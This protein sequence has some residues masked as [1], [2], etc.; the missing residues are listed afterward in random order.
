[1]EDFV[2]SKVVGEQWTHLQLS[3]HL[4]SLYPGV[5][6]FSVRSIQRF[7]A[8]KDIH[9]TSQLDTNEVEQAVTEAVTKVG[10]TYGR[11]TMKGLLASE[12][13]V[14][15]EERVGRALR[16]VN[17][18]HHHARQTV[19][20]RLINPIPY[21]ADYFG[22]KLHIDQNEKLVMYGVTHICAVD[23]Y[24][25]MIVG[26]LSM[27]IKNTVEIYSNL[28]RPILSEYGLW[29]Q[30]RVDQGKEWYLM[31]FIQEQLAHLRHNTQRPPHLQTSSKLNHSVERMWVEINGRVNYP[32]KSCLISLQESGEIN[33]EDEHVKF[34]VSWFSIRVANVGTAMAVS[35]WNHHRIP[36]KKGGIPIQLMRE[37]NMAMSVPYTLIPEATDAVQLMESKGSHLT[38]FSSFGSDPLANR[39][40]LAQQSC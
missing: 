37:N 23:G 10:P 17:P 14:I 16:Q 26:F 31:L 11:K 18:V 5:R 2:H 13:K 36:G 19:T 12:G 4:Q 21:H 25:R 29:D 15:G 24:S 27:P 40:D 8:S 35:S 20:A 22:H 3:C 6:G 33:M 34:C 9:R 1:M 7:C 32:I 28:Y 30:I 39:V 38:W